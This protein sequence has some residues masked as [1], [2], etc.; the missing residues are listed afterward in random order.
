MEGTE[1]SSSGLTGSRRRVAERGSWAALVAATTL[2]LGAAQPVRTEI[3]ADPSLAA[4]A[5]RLV[6]HSYR[7]NSVVEGGLPGAGARPI[8]AVQREVTAEELQRGVNVAVLE[9]ERTEG[10]TIIVA[11]VERGVPDLEFGGFR[12]RPGRDA[13]LGTARSSAAV[14][15]AAVVL[16]RRHQD[17]G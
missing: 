15:R 5:Y 16:R 10:G 12:A 1:E 8:G 11:W 9:L 4:G 13:Y 7:E 6:V 2:G 3:K 17:M 14:E